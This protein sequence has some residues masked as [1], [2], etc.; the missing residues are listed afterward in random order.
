MESMPK[1]Q[2]I[3]EDGV[4]R[5]TEPLSLKQHQRV[6]IEITALDDEQNSTQPRSGVR[7]IP[8]SKFKKL[9]NPNVDREEL[10]RK[11]AAIPGSMDDDI[12]AERDER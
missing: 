9:A 3:Y 8:A 4:L 11:L 6:E 7:L 5:P 12:R 10:T 2:A 1:L